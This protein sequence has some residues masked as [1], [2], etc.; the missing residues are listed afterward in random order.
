MKNETKRLQTL[1]NSVFIAFDEA[2]QKLILLEIFFK[3][4]VSKQDDPSE[5]NTSN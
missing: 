1:I 4:I 3:D 2:Y 5:H